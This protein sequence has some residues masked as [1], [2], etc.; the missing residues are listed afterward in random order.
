MAK[1]KLR[2]SGAKAHTF[3]TPAAPKTV[4]T[5]KG[6]LDYTEND[7]PTHDGKPDKDDET[8]DPRGASIVQTVKVVFDD[9]GKAEVTEDEWRAIQ[10]H[11]ANAG[12]VR[13]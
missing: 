9:E 1:V 6:V 8:A 13:V 2:Y 7:M 3:Q 4:A 10:P 12:I 11:A 5:G